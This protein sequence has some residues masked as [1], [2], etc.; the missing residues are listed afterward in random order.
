MTDFSI[1]NSA[2]ATALLFAKTCQCGTLIADDGTC[3]IGC[4]DGIAAAAGELPDWAKTTT[5]EGK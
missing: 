3:S 4:P 5:A 2:L 1:S